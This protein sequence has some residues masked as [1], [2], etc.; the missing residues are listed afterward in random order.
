M[1][2]SAIILAMAASCVIAACMTTG[3]QFGAGPVRIADG[4]SPER[5]AHP[6]IPDPLIGIALADSQRMQIDSIRASYWLQAKDVT[7]F[8]EFDNLV[9]REEVDERGVLTPV[10]RR[11]YDAHMADARARAKRAAAEAD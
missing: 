8:D 4:D 11:E 10:Q 5:P 3:G 9:R 6:P 2:K 1:I 7:T